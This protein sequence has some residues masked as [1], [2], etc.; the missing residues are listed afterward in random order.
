M[1]QEHPNNGPRDLRGELL[2]K[3]AA[4]GAYVPPKTTG[5]EPPAGPA[6]ATG[7]ATRITVEVASPRRMIAIAR[8][9]LDALLADGPDGAGGHRPAFARRELARYRR[10]RAHLD[11]ALADGLWLDEF[12]LAPRHGADVFTRTRA[13]VFALDGVGAREVRWVH[14]QIAAADEFLAHVVVH[15]DGR[16]AEAAGA[17]LRLARRDLARGQ[18]ATTMGRLGEAIERYR[19]AWREY[20]RPVLRLMAGAG[21]AASMTIVG[22]LYGP[23]GPAVSASAGAS[24]TSTAGQ[25]GGRGDT[26]GRRRGQD[27]P[28]YYLPVISKGASPDE[29]S[30]L[31]TPAPTGTPTATGTPTPT[32]TPTT[33]PTATA[34]PTSTP[35]GTPTPTATPTS[36]PTATPT[37]TYTF[38]PTPTSTNTPVLGE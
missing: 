15:E 34:T 19:D 20:Q 29:G 24:T 5:G 32:A 33:T 6:D 8:E 28:T 38:T 10:A 23:V 37:P 30:P 17:D 35:T 14:A 36:T 16:R 21:V 31:P 26:T 4:Q 1:S 22:S 13:A 18:V 27:A 3:L 7:E 11:A 9:R 2:R 25:G 12:H